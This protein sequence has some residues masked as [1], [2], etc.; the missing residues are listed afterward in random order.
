MA[1]APR[2]TTKKKAAMKK[3]G[4]KKAV[5]KKAAV[6]TGVRGRKPG[7]KV[8]AKKKVV[9]PG[10]GLKK[11]APTKK[12]AAAKTGMSA[13]AADVKKQ[14]R[15]KLKELQAEL[16]EAKAELKASQKREE[17]LVKMSE[18]KQVATQKF[19]EKWTKQEM[20]KLEQSLAPKKKRRRRKSV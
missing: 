9:A 1:R 6:K 17:M 5:V 12:K 8:A 7:V 16:K 4:I 14:L 20:A 15:D 2:S 19:L 18:A 10:V 11:R 3:A 13:V